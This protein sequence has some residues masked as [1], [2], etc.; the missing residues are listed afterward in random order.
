M[1]K[2]NWSLRR[3]LFGQP[4]R[5]AELAAEKLPKWKA[6]P[7]FSSDALS[8][9]GYGPEQI[10]LVLVLPGLILYPYF[11]WVVAGI[12]LLLAIV[13]LSYSQVIHVHPDGG[14]SYSIAKQYLGEYP[15]LLAAAALFA[16]YVLTVAVSVSSGTAALV[17]AWPELLP[18]RMG[19]D[20]VVLFGLLMVINLRGI[21]EASSA[22]VWPTYAFIFTVLALTASGLYQVLVMERAPLILPE[23][24]ASLPTTPILLWLLLRAFANG[25]SSMTGVEAI[26]NGAD[27]FREPRARQASLTIA[28]MATLLA[29][30][31]G[32]V[33]YL[34]VHFGILPAGNST[35]LSRLAEFVWGR[36][37]VYFV[38]QFL[39]M[40]ILYLAANTA[41]NGLPPLLSLLARD[42]YMP[43]YLAARGARLGYNNGIILLSIAAA[44]LIILFHGNVEHLISLYALG[45]F[46]SFTLAQLGLCVHWSTPAA[47][48]LPRLFLNGFGAFV[49]GCVAL[50]II[51]TKFVHGVWIIMLFM[52]LMMWVF[53]RI[54]A[55]YDYVAKTLLLTR[56]ECDAFMQENL[57]EHHI[58]LPIAA[59]TKAVVRAIRYAKSLTPIEYVHA[60]H[61]ATNAAY[62]EKVRKQWEEWLPELP[63]TILP[64]PYRIM[65]EPFIDY[66]ECFRETHPDAVITV[67]I[68]E[69]EVTNPR[70]RI[71]HNQQG[72]FLRWELLNDL[73][74]VVTTVP[75]R[76]DD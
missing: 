44:I 29:L 70:H 66:V 24:S 32:G 74:I 45:V 34:I 3:F 46:L 49:T 59:P 69:F 42:G 43:R 20:L 16:D 18:Y 26:A 13:T 33:S 65:N 58:I 36:G 9:V 39:T 19:I 22:F 21:R 1:E 73:D 67:V 28:M 63:L 54:R 14:G 31:L 38:F 4:L 2:I 62:G 52:P 47:R 37:T 48:S 10:A 64:S 75:L 68:P 30:I 53:K 7:I 17:S 41:Y 76:I 50:V 27:S 40:I 56:E 12:I 60:V 55:H 15:A 25:C 23:A 72:L 35:L 51:L 61:V 6:L 8:S 71:L 11:I 5:S 57:G